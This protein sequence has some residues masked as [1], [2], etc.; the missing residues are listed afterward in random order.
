M[1]W[2]KKGF[3]AAIC[4]LI[5]IGCGSEKEADE[6]VL[7]AYQRAEIIKRQNDTFGRKHYSVCNGGTIVNL[8]VSTFLS[9]EIHDVV[10]LDPRITQ[11]AMKQSEKND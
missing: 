1:E 3:L 5:F 11:C 8:S 2:L 10:S 9:Y 4:M 6:F 7:K